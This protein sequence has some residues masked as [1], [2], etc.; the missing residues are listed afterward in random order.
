MSEIELERREA[1]KTI[2]IFLAVLTLFSFIA[3]FA[4]F[5]LNPTSI[6]VG[7]L[8]I[9]PALAALITLK[10]RKKP[11]KGL[12]WSLKNLKYLNLKFTLYSF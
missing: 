9:S 3:Y 11:I 8:M 7:A 1:G 12:P 5:K 10:I 6:Y 2:F 4:I